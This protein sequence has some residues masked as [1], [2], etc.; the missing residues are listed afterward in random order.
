MEERVKLLEAQI[1]IA[2]SSITK[3]EQALGVLL[4]YLMINKTFFDG[5]QVSKPAEPAK[6]E[7]K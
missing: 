6:E 3:L 5:L 7:S 4:Q 2:M 1:T